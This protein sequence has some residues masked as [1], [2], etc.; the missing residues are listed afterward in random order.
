LREIV[1]TSSGVFR[2]AD[3]KPTRYL[4]DGQKFVMF[5]CKE[6]RGCHRHHH[7]GIATVI[8]GVT[9]VEEEKEAALV[10]C[11]VSEEEREKEK[12]CRCNIFCS[13]K[14]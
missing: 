11:P 8:L 2:N 12:K 1:I 9:S 5:H 7:D 6:D 10:G 4:P 3:M 14:R 13:S